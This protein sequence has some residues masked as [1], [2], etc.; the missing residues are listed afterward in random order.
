MSTST[1]RKFFE[2]AASDD[3]QKRH[4]TVIGGM[5]LDHV[6]ARD[7]DLPYG[8]D[9]KYAASDPVYQKFKAEA[10]AAPELNSYTA[11]GG[12]GANTAIVLS[13]LNRI[14]GDTVEVTLMTKIGENG[15][16]S[17]IKEEHLGGIDILDLAAGQETKVPVNEIT[18][19]Q[20]GRLIGRQSSFDF[21]SVSVGAAELSTMDTILAG[22]DLV[23]IQTKL[24]DLAMHGAQTAYSLSIPVVVDFGNHDSPKDLLDFASFALLPAE[25]KFPDMNSE[26]PQ[27]LLERAYQHVQKNNGYAAVSSAD[28]ITQRISAAQDGARGLIPSLTIN[29]V[30]TLGAGDTRDGAFCF[31]LLRGDEPDTALRKAN[32][33][34][35]LSCEYYGRDW[36]VHLAERLKAFPEFQEDGLYSPSNDNAE[37]AP[38]PLDIQNGTAPE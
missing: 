4:I 11:L 13:E 18:C 15:L 27:A 7:V 29:K 31:F 26:D 16:S 34:A 1:P 35:S 17:V 3:A 9:A 38:A 19:F 5:N 8:A 20:S 6:Q 21:N 36:T 33:I 28:T 2:T 37:T 23:M 32:I 12:G 24:P 10:D 22:T 30:D 14:F 25:H